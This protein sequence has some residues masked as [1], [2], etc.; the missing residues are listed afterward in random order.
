MGYS[1]VRERKPPGV[2]DTL[3][4]LHTFHH[5]G[6]EKELLDLLLGEGWLVR[7]NDEESAS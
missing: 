6:G 7:R 4:G 3:L 1:A 2:G 5:L